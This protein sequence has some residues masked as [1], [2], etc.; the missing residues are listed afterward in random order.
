MN[1]MNWYQLLIKPPFTPPAWVFAPAWIFLYIT[2][3]ISFVIFLKTG[4]SR[5]KL[6]PIGLFVAQLILNFL[7]S[8]VFFGSKN[9]GLGLIIITLLLVLLFFTVF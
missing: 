7:W 6:L 4:V 1:N 3:G 8:P 2:I 9:I 5:E